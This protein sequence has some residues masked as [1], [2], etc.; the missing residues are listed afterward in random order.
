MNKAHKLLEYASDRLG[1]HMPAPTGIA[2]SQAVMLLA[3]YG[4]T[5]MPCSVKTIADPSGLSA[6]ETE[7]ALQDAH[8][9]GIIG[10]SGTWVAVNAECLPATQSSKEASK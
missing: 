10:W 9:R 4:R 2:A 1:S 6:E 7:A 3:Q 5:A 8:D